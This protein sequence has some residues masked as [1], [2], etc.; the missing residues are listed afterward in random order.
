MVR[1]FSI[2]AQLCAVGWYR[3]GLIPA[4]REPCHRVAMKTKYIG[5]FMISA[6]AAPVGDRWGG[7]WQLAPVV[8][9]SDPDDRPE[10]WVPAT[11]WTRSEAESAAFYEALEEAEQRNRCSNDVFVDIRA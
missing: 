4:G 2:D 6:D 8:G 9:E 10:M 1:I 3:A 7:V 11:Y 5:S